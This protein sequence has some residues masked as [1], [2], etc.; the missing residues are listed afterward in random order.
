MAGPLKLSD[1]ALRALGMNNWAYVLQGYSRLTQKEV[2]RRLDLAPS[3]AQ[4][5]KDDHFERAMQFLAA[6]DLKVVGKDDTALPD[7]VQ[8]AYLTL[9]HR[10]LSR[11]LAERQIGTRDG[12]GRA[13]EE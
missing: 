12:G 6:L 11:Q 9:A 3:T 10:E 13:V 5:F 2:A 1:E 7:A 8:A 4:E